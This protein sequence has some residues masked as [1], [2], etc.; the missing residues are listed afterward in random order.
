MVLSISLN[1]FFEDRI[2]I[3]SWLN[4]FAQKSTLIWLYTF[5]E[6][7]RYQMYSI[8]GLHFL[9]KITSCDYFTWYCI[10]D[11][12]PDI[13]GNYPFWNNNQIIHEMFF[14]KWS[15]CHFLRVSVSIKEVLLSLWN[16]ACRPGLLCS[17]TITHQ[18]RYL[19][20]ICFIKYC[21]YVIGY[22][23]LLTGYCTRPYCN[24]Y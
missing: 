3:W 15:W 22:W 14:F 16:T 2:M 5:G 20:I 7:A 10:C 24:P 23:I 1:H 17:T 13:S 12:T 18:F 4:H 21:T 9:E 19:H 8:L 11:F 6:V